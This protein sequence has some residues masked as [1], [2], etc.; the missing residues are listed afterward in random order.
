[1]LAWFRNVMGKWFAR[2]LFSALMALFVVWGISNAPGLMSGGSAVA[3]IGGQ[4]VDISLVQAE[5]QRELTQAEQTSPSP[6]I[7]TRQQIARAALAAILRQR[8]MRQEEQAIGIAAPAAVIRAKIF[9]IPAFQTNGAFDQAK[10]NAI[11]QQNGI[12]ADR[13]VALETDNLANTQLVQALIAGAGAP[14]ALVDQVFAFI[15]QSRTAEMVTVPTAA[16][17]PPPPPADAVLR[18]YWKN[19]PAQFTAP[20]YRTIKLVILAPAVLAPSEPVSDA[21]LAAAYAQTAAQEKI[22]ASR[23][24]Q[25]ITTSDSGKAASLAAS[26]KTGASWAAVQAAAAKAGAAAV[27]LDHQRQNQFPSTDLA[28]AVFAA[29]PGA[30]TGPVQGPFGYF[31][32]KVTDAV[33]AGAPPLSQVAAQLKQQIQLQKAQADVNADIDNVQDALAGQTPLDKLPGNLGL[34]AVEGTLDSNGNALDGTPAPIPGTKALRAAIIKAVFAAHPGDAPTLITGPDGG[35]FAFSL[36]S[37]TPPALQPYDQVQP[38]VAAAWTQDQI[39]RAAEA[40]A[41]DML[42]A[43]DAGKTVDAAAAAAGYAVATS[44]PIT[45]TAPPAGLPSDFVQILFSLKPGQA[46]MEQTPDGFIVAV[47]AK[48]AQPTPAD[49]PQDAAGIAQDMTKSLQNDVAES[50]LGG[51]QTRDKVRV[52]PKLFAQIYQ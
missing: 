46:T 30:I 39:S 2:V 32:F 37:I 43:V 36:D 21:E 5:Y 31:V 13:F 28:A 41:A 14:P 20:E 27:E 6:D 15:S 3:H 24:V 33:A 52:D 4:P 34:T 49:D 18:R 22:P 17:T 29:T 47:L 25:I 8:A 51:L 45:R 10:F 16:Q 23:S 1:M 11:L 9:A 44:P 35:Y 7:A 12:S 26:W 48:I 40:K 50:F 42:A 38:K 19:H